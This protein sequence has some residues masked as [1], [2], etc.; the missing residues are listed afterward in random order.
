MRRNSKR[1]SNQSIRY[2]SQQQPSSK[3]QKTSFVSESYLSTLSAAGV[4]LHEN[5]P[6]VLNTSAQEFKHQLT[7]SL[8]TLGNVPSEESVAEFVK[9]Y[10]QYVMESERL[11]FSLQPMKN[12]IDTESSSISFSRVL[13]NIDCLQTKI[14][15]ILIEKLLEFADTF[16]VDARYCDVPKLILIQLHWLDIIIE[17][18]VIFD[19]L[20]EVLDVLPEDIQRDIVQL[21]PEIIISYDESELAKKLQELLENQSHLVAACIE[22]LSNLNIPSD[23]SEEILESALERISSCSVPD[24]PLLINYISSQ[25]TSK[26]HI[27]VIGE[28]RQRLDVETCLLTRPNASSTPVPT[29]TNSG[30]STSYAILNSICSSLQYVKHV[31]DAWIKVIGSVDDE[32]SHSSLDLFI[33]CIINEITAKRKAVFDLVIAKVKSGLFSAELVDELFNSQLSSVPVIFPSTL[34][35]CSKLISHS[36]NELVLSFVKSL[37]FL[38]FT[39]FDA[40][41]QKE[42]I[43]SLIDTIGS[44]ISHNRDCVLSVLELLVDKSLHQMIKFS[45]FIKSVLDYLNQFSLPQVRRLYAILSTLTCSSGSPLT[46]SV[47]DEFHSI[48]RKQLHHHEPLFHQMGIIGAVVMIKQLT[49]KGNIHETTINTRDTS[50]ST[51]SLSQAKLMLEQVI[52][53]CTDLSSFYEEM[54]SV[55]SERE[56]H[57]DFLK[58]LLEEVTGKFQE[59]YVIEAVDLTTQSD[60]SGGLSTK[61]Q[62]NLDPIAADG[63]SD[64]IAVELFDLL[65]SSSAQKSTLAASLPSHFKLLRTCEQVLNGGLEEVDALLGCPIVLCSPS[66]LEKDLFEELSMHERQLICSSLVHTINWFRELVSSFASESD[67]EMNWKVL[68]RIKNICSLQDQLKSL[69]TVTSGPFPTLD[70]STSSII[71]NTDKRTS[72]KTQK[73]QSVLVT[74]MNQSMAPTAATATGKDH[75][76][77]VSVKKGGGG[78]GNLLYDRFQLL[79]RPLEMSAYRALGYK[80]ISRSLVDT[81]MQPLESQSVKLKPSE[82]LFLL[83]SL[84]RSLP[85]GSFG[86]KARINNEEKKRFVASF[87]EN[88]ILDSLCNHLEELHKIE[89]EHDEDLDIIYSC[90]LSL[91]SI[92][93]SFFSLPFTNE[94]LIESLKVLSNRSLELS[95]SQIFDIDSIAGSAIVYCQTFIGRIPNLTIA[96]AYCKLLVSIAKA[97]S[98]GLKINISKSCE[99]LLNVNWD[100]LK[101]VTHKNDSLEFVIKYYIEYASNPVGV[102]EELC[103]EVITELIEVEEEEACIHQSTKIPTLSLTTFSCYFRC[104]MNAINNHA[105]STLNK[106]VTLSQNQLSGLMTLEQCSRVMNMLMNYVKSFDSKPVIAAGLKL[107]MTF[108]EIFSKQGLPLIKA[109]FKTRKDNVLQIIKIFQKTTRLLQNYCGHS[110]VVANPLLTNYVPKVKRA[111]ETFVFE[112]KEV[113]VLNG[114]SEAFGV[115]NLKNRTLKGDEIL[116]QSQV[117]NDSQEVEEEEEREEEEEEE[118]EIDES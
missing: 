43:V 55:V 44:G 90:M 112:V 52:N 11:L 35:L 99:K 19:K 46:G 16:G 60:A 42:V 49:S 22:A 38:L 78:G 113:L 18:K 39:S 93:S 111:L 117:T 98:N 37:Y 25:V 104:M 14:A 24:L 102:V 57:N 45:V 74:Q 26:N 114:C 47:S 56:I 6:P 50:L 27:K 40:I 88:G 5:S 30:N 51:H 92:M 115:K 85:K 103:T 71:S 33:L 118:E 54:A 101:G 8:S 7:K 110:K 73:D 84:K 9:G 87:V 89:D 86:F 72:S 81:H 48:I 62:F 1:K 32:S 20:F 69:L 106:N 15:L 94:S 10:E 58:Y 82:L 13:L 107:G 4:T 17:E 63:D 66:K 77:T 36:S 61:Q 105:K 34:A 108:V 70:V 21:L 29:L 75:N 96:A 2:P 68:M 79:F 28:L 65:K 76:D 100:E 83:E 59:I 91:Y 3:R 109:S 31:P 64:P 41:K 95:S 97:S 67:K 116:T 12:N 53:A 80:A 23:L